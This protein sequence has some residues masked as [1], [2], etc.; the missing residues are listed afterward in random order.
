MYQPVQ[1]SNYQVGFKLD[2]IGVGCGATVSNAGILSSHSTFN[3]QY[4]LEIEGASFIN[5]DC[6]GKRATNSFKDVNLTSVTTSQIRMRAA[7]A[8]GFSTVYVTDWCTLQ[9]VHTSPPLPQIPSPM[10][11]P[12]PTPPLVSHPPSPPS[13]PSPHVEEAGRSREGRRG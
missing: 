2:S 10:L 7:H 4:V 5:G 13:H 12:P 1:S 6:A 3:G 9:I 8:N 11:Q